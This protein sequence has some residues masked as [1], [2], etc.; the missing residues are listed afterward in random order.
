[1]ICSIA[2]SLAP[3]PVHPFDQS[4]VKRRLSRPITV[5]AALGLNRS[6]P[7]TSDLNFRP[8]ELKIQLRTISTPPKRDS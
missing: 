6:C 4:A 1:M 7:I 2:E 5:L 8:D 3:F